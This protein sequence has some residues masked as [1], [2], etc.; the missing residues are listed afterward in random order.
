MNTFEQRINLLQ[1]ES[2][3]LRSFLIELPPG[4]WGMQ[5]ACEGWEIRDVMAHL[6]GGASFYTDSITRGLK[7]DSGTP[8]GRP[9]PSTTNGIANAES[10]ANRAIASRESMGDKVFSEFV[11]ANDKLNTL[12]DKLDDTEWDKSCY[13]PATIMSVW[14]LSTVRVF[15]LA[16]HGLDIRSSIDE[17]A[18]LS[19]DCL[20]VIV[21]FIP[22]MLN[23][24]FQPNARLASPLRYRFE[25]TGAT[26]DLV[27]EGDK[28]FVEYDS[29]ES[30]TTVFRC[31]N[32]TYVLLMTG[33]TE[34]NSAIANGNLTIE[35]DNDAARNFSKWFR[36]A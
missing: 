12:F 25:L 34:I 30:A 4:S 3:R 16:L 2:E 18:H 17:T 10:I 32:E 8:E 27:I 11:S 28:V 5:S 9:S 20:P 29:D 1:S 36:G 24:L 19:E 13:F 6:A 31:D 23:W 21:G 35:G 15:E 26:Q 14:N 33:R 22:K 7:G